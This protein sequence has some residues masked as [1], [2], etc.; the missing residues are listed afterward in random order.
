MRSIL[1]AT[2]T[3]GSP[4]SEGLSSGSAI[5]TSQDQDEEL[6]GFFHNRKRDSHHTVLIGRI[7]ACRSL[8]LLHPVLPAQ[9]PFIRR[10]VAQAEAE[11]PETTSADT[12]TSHA[13][14]G[15]LA[16]GPKLIRNLLQA[17][18]EAEQAVKDNG[19]EEMSSE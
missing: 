2:K 5:E 1:W 17:R 8:Q 15:P 16:G 10:K 14:P 4:S 7:R 11:V 12:K 9:N 6:A 3:V 19:L 18:V 13:G